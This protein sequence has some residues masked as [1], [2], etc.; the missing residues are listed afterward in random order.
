MTLLR[1]TCRR[2]HR[3]VL[4][5]ETTGKATQFGSLEETLMMATAIEGVMPCIDFSHLHA[6][7]CGEY[8]TIEEFRSFLESVESALGR[9]GTGEHALPHIR[10]SLWG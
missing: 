3:L 7:S 10:H 1:R 4:R 5:P 8:N 2:G 9:E 6:R